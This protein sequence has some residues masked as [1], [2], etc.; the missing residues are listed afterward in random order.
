MT[1]NIKVSS[2]GT[3]T[4][5]G[6]STPQNYYDGLSKQWAINDGVVQGLDYSSK[7]Y[8]NKSKEEFTKAQSEV[9]KAQ[10]A[11]NEA[12]SYANLANG[13]IED[14]KTAITELEQQAEINIENKKDE[15]SLE[16]KNEKTTYLNEVKSASQTAIDT[17]S[18]VLTKNQITNCI[19]EIPQNIKLELNNGTLTL[20]AGSKVV[21]PNGANV[22]DEVITTQDF[23][24]TYTVDGKVVIFYIGNAIGGRGLSE[25]KSGTTNPASPGTAYYDTDD[26]HLYYY[27]ANGTEFQASFPLAICTVKNGAIASIDKVFNGLGFIGGTNF[28]LPGV[29]ALIPNGRNEDGTLNNLEVETTKVSTIS[30]NTSRADTYITLMSNGVISIS[31]ILSS[32]LAYYDEE[33]NLFYQ[34]ANDKGGAACVV[35]LFNCSATGVDKFI[36][37]KPFRAID[38]ND[39]TEVSSWPMPSSKYINL[40]LGTSGATYTAPNNGY[41]VL[42]K[43]STGAGQYILLDNTSVGMSAQ[44][45]AQSASQQIMT[46][47]PAKKGDSLQISYSTGG[48]T[49]A[50]KFIYAEGVK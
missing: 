18:N 26:N 29:K 40:T 46:Y 36:T 28:A 42:A 24:G 5:I 41:L 25:C 45:I 27:Y 49:N 12:Q 3:K 10:G 34:N 16:L 33:K 38:W 4:I 2:A 9:I 7:Y 39:K 35:G 19:K 8:A 20:K 50:F 22:F 23:S 17:Y 13:I 31:S 47:I 6:A 11:S 15:L 14:G 43:T 21:V 48:A 44:I 1:N 30:I 37:K 32:G